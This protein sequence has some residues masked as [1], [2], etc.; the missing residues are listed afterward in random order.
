MVEY[1][2]W[3]GRVYGFER[4]KIGS[5][6]EH[7]GGTAME[8]Q[9]KFENFIMFLA[10]EADKDEL[11]EAIEALEEKIKETGCEEPCF[12]IARSD[13]SRIDIVKPFYF[14]DGVKFYAEY[15]DGFRA[16]FLVCEWKDDFEKLEALLKDTDDTLYIRYKEY[17]ADLGYMTE[18]KQRRL[19]TL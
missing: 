19:K 10:K 15:Y 9:R 6:F 13:W 17:L 5:T 18:Q 8:E 7:I 16:P 14:R 4:W 1:I 12:G 3:N 11:W 2:C